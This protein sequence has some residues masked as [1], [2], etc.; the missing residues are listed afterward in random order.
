MSY[1][2]SNFGHWNIDSEEDLDFYRQVQMTKLINEYVDILNEKGINRK[3]T[4]FVVNE[5]FSTQKGRKYVKV[6]QSFSDGSNLSVHSFVN[7]KTGEVFK[8]ASWAAPAKGARYN[9]NT[10]MDTLRQVADPYGSYL[11][12]R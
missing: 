11:Y 4:Q 2:D 10:D 9:L 1:Y 12:K 5:K 7:P 8:A 6:V 3:Y